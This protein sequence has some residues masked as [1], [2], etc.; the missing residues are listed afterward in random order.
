MAPQ[1]HAYVFRWRIDGQDYSSSPLPRSY[2][3]DEVREQAADLWLT[4]PA[5]SFVIECDS[6][7]VQALHFGDPRR[8]LEE[9]GR[10]YRA[11]ARVLQRPPLA[12]D[13]RALK[14]ALTLPPDRLAQGWVGQ[15]LAECLGID[16]FHGRVSDD[17]WQ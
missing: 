2:D 11:A 13:L 16:L 10:L 15:A 5:R 1:P 12:G 17:P 8:T 3:L 9:E 14:A 6:R 4:G 7:P